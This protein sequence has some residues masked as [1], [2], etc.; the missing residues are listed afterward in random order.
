[1]RIDIAGRSA[2][3]YGL[4]PQAIGAEPLGA[5][6]AVR[7]EFVTLSREQI[8]EILSED[9]LPEAIQNAI[10]NLLKAGVQFVLGLD[11][12]GDLYYR[13]VSGSLARLSIGEEGQ[14]LSVVS[15]FPAWVDV[16]P[17][18]PPEEPTSATRLLVA[19]ENMVF[20][21]G[22]KIYVYDGTYYL[23]QINGASYYFGSIPW[24]TVKA[25]PQKGFIY[26][27]PNGTV[28][29]TSLS[30]TSSFTAEASVTQADFDSF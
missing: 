16:F 24:T 1:M 30:D 29:L 14:V 9:P 11:A 20:S 23:E 12:P 25:N 3:V 13:S 6:A 7:S 28:A 21:N 22:A 18:L 8:L 2:K 27:R 26:V 5:V 15:G 10:D 17:S 19:G 4:T